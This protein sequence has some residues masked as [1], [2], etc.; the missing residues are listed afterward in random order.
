MGF[1]WLGLGFGDPGRF[2]A[3]MLSVFWPR[4]FGGGEGAAFCHLYMFW[5]RIWGLGF[6]LGCEEMRLKF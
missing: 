2:G 4:G 1:L 3:F 5:L 6:G